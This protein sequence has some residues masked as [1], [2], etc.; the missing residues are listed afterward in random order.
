MIPAETIFEEEDIDSM[1]RETFQRYLDT[2]I[3]C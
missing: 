2:L 1:A 3:N